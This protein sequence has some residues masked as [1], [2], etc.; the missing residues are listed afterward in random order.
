M[1]SPSLSPSSRILKGEGLI[2]PQK[3]RRR[4]APYTKPFVKVTAPNQVWCVDFKGHFKTRNGKKTYPLTVTDA[5][6][7][8]LICCEIVKDP[9]GREVRKLFESCFIEFGL[10]EAIRSDTGA[11]FATLVRSTERGGL[12]AS[13]VKGQRCVSILE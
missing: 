5:F 13:L 6:S 12:N 8:F 3:P 10:P 7:R 1:A 11:P 4:T 2:V 9:N